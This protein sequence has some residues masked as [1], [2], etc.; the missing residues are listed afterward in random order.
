MKTKN[1]K[2]NLFK[3]SLLAIFSLV[4]LAQADICLAQASGGKTG[5]TTG[6]TSGA[7]QVKTTGITKRVTLSKTNQCVILTGSV[8]SKNFD[9]YIFSATK[10]QTVIA[11]PY[12]YG[13]ETNRPKDDEEG[14]SGFVIVMPGGE[15]F[16]DPQDV[17]FNVEKTGQY[18]VLVRPAYKRTTG[19]YAL[20]LSVTDKLPAT[21]DDPSKPPKCP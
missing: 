16:E 19:R 2:T 7:G 15:K 18:K 11:D 5:K 3:G 1:M 4:F 17:Q 13:K 8:Q 10:G 6:P 21:I 20:K 12:F 9:T 14:L